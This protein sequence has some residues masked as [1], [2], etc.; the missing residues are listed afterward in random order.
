MFQSIVPKSF[1]RDIDLAQCW[2]SL[3][4]VAW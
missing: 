4:G 2:S 1:G 3:E